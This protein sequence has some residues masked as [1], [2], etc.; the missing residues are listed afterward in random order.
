MQDYLLWASVEVLVTLIQTMITMTLARGHQRNVRQFEGQYHLRRTSHCRPGCGG[1]CK[2]APECIHCVFV[3]EY[4]CVW[5]TEGPHTLTLNGTVRERVGCV[6][7][8]SHHEHLVRLM[9]MMNMSVF[10]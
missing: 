9:M 8:R 4:H 2:D 1:L 5:D 6:V 10:Q 3:R 7:R